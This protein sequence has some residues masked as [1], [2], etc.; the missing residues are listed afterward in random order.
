ML[1]LSAPLAMLACL[2]M[3]GALAAEPGSY[4]ES[5]RKGAETRQPFALSVA[6]GASGDLQVRWAIRP[7][8]YLYRHSLHATRNGQPVALTLPAGAPKDDPTFGHVEIYQRDL[9]ARVRDPG[10]DGR[11]EI[12]FQGCSEAGIC[13]P[14][15]LGRIDLSTLAVQTVSPPPAADRLE[16]SDR[17]PE[18]ANRHAFAAAGSPAN[19]GA[20]TPP[21]ETAALFG[22]G[23]GWA[24]VAFLGFGLLLALTPCIFPMIP[25]LAGI[26]A[27]SGDTLTRRRSLAL[28]VVY[29]LAMASAYG[30]VGAVAGWSGA[31]L[32]AALQT[33]LALGLTAAVFIALALSMFGLFELALP[34][35]LAGRLAG[36]GKGGSLGGAALLGFGSALIVGPCVTPP[37][38]GAMLY[39][40]STGD[41]AAGAA[42]LFMLGLGMGLPLILVGVFGPSLLPKAGLWLVRVKQ[43]FGVIFLAVA[44]LLAGRLLP[45]PLTLALLGVLL[46][47]ASVYFGGFDRLTETSGAAARLVRGGGMAAALYGA[48][49]IVGAAG[50]AE[51]PLRPLAFPSAAAVASDLRSSGRHVADSVSFDAAVARASGAGPILVDFTADWCSVCKANAAVMASPA[52]QPRLAGLAQVTAD[53][54]TYDTATRALMERFDVVGPPTMFLLDAQGREIPGTRMIGAVSAEDIARRLDAAGA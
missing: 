19:T 40:A 17:Q 6:R 47:S 46:I 37:L 53:V 29:V 14:P 18:R 13:Y 12:A 1:R 31:N 24:L 43:A 51:D 49:L 15:Q 20:P 48:T 27:R 41:A 7:G 8:T 38:A 36:R 34:P 42:A 25:I 33:P 23:L 22:A 11:L 5:L 52:L 35:R 3:A 16:Q 30:L 21:P 32:Q 2:S 9:M 54:T 28:T 10:G 4:F 44:I 45:P 50:G 39:A 26:L